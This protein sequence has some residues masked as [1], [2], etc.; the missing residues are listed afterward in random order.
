[1]LLN[2]VLQKENNNLDV[3]RV[4]AAVMVIYGH[5]NA[6]LP[7]EG[8][9]DIVA[10]FLPFD[11]SGSLAVKLFFFLSGLV[12][13]NSLIEKD[14]YQFVASRFFRLW[15]ALTVVLVAWAFVIG[16]IVSTNS[17]Y[18]YFTN[19]QVYEYVFHGL[20]MD[21]RYDLPGVFQ[22]GPTNAVNGS[23][24]SIPFEVYAY[25]VLVAVF[26]LDAINSKPLMVVFFLVIVIDPIV[27]NKLLFTWLPQNPEVNLLAPCFAFGS[28]FAVFKDS[29][30]INFKCLAGACVVF[31]LFRASL[32]NFYLFYAAFFYFIVFVSS[33]AWMLKFKPRF[34]VSYGMYLW[35]W[36]VQQIMAQNFQPLGVLFNQISSVIIAA[37]LGYVS[38]RC[39]E[40]PL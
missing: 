22:G 19:P 1:M 21:I 28:L 36:P 14:V 8:R 10:R 32:Y 33:R 6:F 26:L 29:I 27:G 3:F 17:F 30:K 2:K 4:I 24:W 37:L 16:P 39:I 31:Y 15:P 12:V 11:Y 40:F 18:E 7:G 13:T 9:G 38:W 23:L 25:I 34:D 35:G 20:I 5:A